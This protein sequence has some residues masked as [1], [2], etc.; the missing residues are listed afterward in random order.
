MR[1]ALLASIAVAVLSASAAALDV[2]YLSGRVNDDAHLLDAPSASALELKLKNYEMRTGRQFAV[3]TIPSLE[4][5]GLEDFSLRVARTW[6]LGRAGIDDGVLLLIAKDDRKVRIEVGYGLEGVLTDAQCGRI[7]RDA[8]VPRFRGGDFAGGVTDGVGA[9]LAV[10]GG[11]GDW[12]APPEKSASRASIWL[13]KFRSVFGIVFVL[14]MIALGVYQSLYDDSPR[15][16]GWYGSGDWSGTGGDGGGFTGG[17][18]SFGGGG[19]S[20]SW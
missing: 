1:R 17:V 10:L 14:L 19:S 6:R 12:Y 3:L 7:I 5:E 11:G 8:I 20:G 18:G 13:A 4:G 2:P 16:Y 9:V 15:S